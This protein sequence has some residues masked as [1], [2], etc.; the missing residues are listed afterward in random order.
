MIIACYVTDVEPFKVADNVVPF[1]GEMAVFEQP[2]FGP[3][4]PYD[5]D[6]SYHSYNMQ[7]L[8]GNR[9]DLFFFT[10]EKLDEKCKDSLSIVLVDKDN[11]CTKI[12]PPSEESYFI[13]KPTKEQ[14]KGCCDAFFFA[15]GSHIPKTIWRKQLP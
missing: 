6:G 10:I 1:F 13:S 11:L 14:F 2:N 15:T 5:A 12:P 8:D 7:F 3:W 9:I 4:P